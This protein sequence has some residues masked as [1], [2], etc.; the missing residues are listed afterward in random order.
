MSA[1]QAA[2][3][4][5]GL[6]LHRC[7]LVTKFIPCA[8]RHSRTGVLKKRDVL[9]QQPE[10]STDIMEKSVIDYFLIYH[11][12]RKNSLDLCLA[13]FCC[14]YQMVPPKGLSKKHKEYSETLLGRDNEDGGG[15]DLLTDEKALY[16][17]MPRPPWIRE[18]V[19]FEPI[20]RVFRKRQRTCIMRCPPAKKGTEEYYRQRLMLFLPG[21]MWCHGVG[22]DVGDGRDSEDVAL[23]CGQK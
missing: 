22:R 16:L 18:D 4:L 19:E 3:L 1:Q 9:A 20:V 12:Q 23:L 2:F 8:P 13:D 6:P 14:E 21:S 7:S 10:D 11:K 15:D 5:L 17:V